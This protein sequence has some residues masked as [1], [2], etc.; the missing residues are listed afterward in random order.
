LRPNGTFVNGERVVAGRRRRDGDELRVGATTLVFREPRRRRNTTFVP[1][2]AERPL[3]LSPA[4]RR[5]LVALCRPFWETG[6]FV[7]PASNKE[8]A[9]ALH[10]SVAAVKT[11]LR[12]LFLRLGVEDVPHNEKRFRLVELAFEQGLVTPADLEPD[13]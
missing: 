8:I 2:P 5:V 10:L 4:Q 9:D 1:R 3:E 12:A 6:A 11:H 13:T 7:R